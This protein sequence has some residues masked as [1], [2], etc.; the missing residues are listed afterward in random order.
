MAHRSDSQQS[1][2]RS[3]A[4]ADAQL[5]VQKSGTISTPLLLQRA[6]AD[7]SSLTP[8]DVKRLQRSVGNR[9]TIRLLS[10]STG[11]QAKLKLGP[12]G[13]QYE[14]EADRVA[15]QVVRQMAR[16][17]PAQRR[18]EDEDAQA[19]PFSQE[20]GDLQRQGES[21]PKTAFTKPVEGKIRQ[22]KPVAATISR[23]QRSP[24][25]QFTKSMFA[26]RHHEE[27]DLAQMKPLHGPEG[28]DV[29]Q[30]VEKQ[31]QTERG[32]GQPLDEGVRTSMEQGFGAD[33]S[34]VRVHT[35]S[36]ADALNRSLNAKAF[37]VGNDVF[38]GKGHYNPSSSG[39]QQ[40]IAHE[41]THTV[42]QGAASVQ[43]QSDAHA[44]NC[45]CSQCQSVQRTSVEGETSPDVI[46]RTGAHLPG[47]HCPSC[48]GVQRKPMAE[49]QRHHSEEDLTAQRSIQ[50]RSAS[51]GRTCS[52]AACGAK[53][54]Q[55]Q[56][57]RGQGP[58]P[59]ANVQPVEGRLS[60]T[61]VR[62][63]G[64]AA[65]TRPAVKLHQPLSVP[66]IQRHSS[67]E[68]QLLGDVPPD[69]IAKIGAWQ[70]LIKQTELVGFFGFRQ[71]KQQEGS[72]TVDGIGTIKK[73]NVM[74]VIA[75]EMQ[76]LSV[77][78]KNPPT[79]T[80]SVD[81]E[82][83][84]GR[85]P[86][87][88]VELVALPAPE[89]QQ[90]LIITY[91]EMNTLA[92]FYGDLETM[93]AADPESRRQIVQSVRQETFF[94]LKNI[95]TQ[96]Q[97]SLTDTEKKDRDVL[98]AQQMMSQNE[99]YN[100]I[101]GQ[102]FG[103]AVTITDYI[104]GKIGQ[105]ELLTGAQSTGAKGVT[106]AY[107]ATLARNACHFVPESWHAWAR[108]HKEALTQAEIAFHAQQKADQIEEELDW[109]ETGE[110][111]PET[112]ERLM[113]RY[114][115]EADEAANEAML[116]NG[117]GD[118]YL[119]DS[120]ASGHMLNKTQ[121]MQWYVQYLD[122][123]DDLTY[124]TEKN[125]RRVQQM[126]YRQPGLAEK[127]LY[128]KSRVRGGSD[129]ENEMQARNPQAVEDIE[130]DDWKDRFD[131][132]GLTIPK[133]L[134]TGSPER[135]LIEWWQEEAMGLKN[136]KTGAELLSSGKINDPTALETSVKKLL[137]DGVV[138]I[139][140]QPVNLRGRMLR[141]DVG[142]NFR[143]KFND[144][145]FALRD[146]YIPKDS[147]RFQQARIES[148]QG[149]DTQYQR[150][151]AAVTYGDYFEFMN[152]SFIQKST[153]ALHDT[154]CTGGLTV[155]S[156]NGQQ[157]FKVYGDDAMFNEG[158]AAGVKDS[159]RTANMSR[160]SILNTIRTGNDG[161]YTTQSI[162]SR[163]PNTVRVDIKNDQGKVVGTSDTEI[164]KWHNP[165]QGPSLRSYCFK[166]VFPAM[167]WSLMQKLGPGVMSTLGHISQDLN[168]HGQEA[169]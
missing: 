63:Q 6:Y 40:L 164:G 35:G 132:L 84:Y 116:N 102:K 126:A 106:N 122:Q 52:C 29:E 107:G 43:R 147:G 90:P 18:H 144:I 129:P 20:S 36:Q 25:A 71:P 27:E 150:M 61:G 130:S 24:N 16:P 46:R 80:K 62:I 68:H 55:P 125:W 47:C 38:F 109:E 32:G 69:Q 155:L 124:F 133:T 99:L 168:V 114:R 49:I 134:R 88:Q 148:Q 82:K 8:K 56:R 5:T 118:H 167:G 44:H 65:A 9:A 60:K 162:L 31:I 138:L 64:K 70:D 146:E 4:R 81:K 120:Y 158:S 26:Q 37:T 101:L 153:N 163:L 112:L 2:D 34:G 11:L 30:S 149:D 128:D 19:R 33:F 100:Q 42:Q 89:G 159:A 87:W 45:A 66:D 105:G 135:P 48:A 1:A 143:G 85:D 79:G 141:K 92:D 98:S 67:W 41:L 103:G 50:R 17:Q 140:N 74:H 151:A 131:A 14:Q 111:D 119:Q 169:F 13:D 58:Q 15:S 152:S 96:L 10:R 127:L 123:T 161:G 166:E 113:K 145:S 53:R 157:V 21:Q 165:D 142:I 75:Q 97:S 39:G 94:Q 154:F 23:V 51:H 104:S 72:I 115:Q 73:G 54:I 93:K 83:L 28:G 77:W 95:Y 86:V 91:G 59:T 7:P 139:V 3:S 160:D 108:Y 117:F 156:G 121:I 78:Q 57:D 137:K 110:D 12:A 136:V 22:L 76:R